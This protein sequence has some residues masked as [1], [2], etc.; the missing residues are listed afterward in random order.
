MKH[1]ILTILMILSGFSFAQDM[2]KKNM[3]YGNMA[4]NEGEFEDALKYFGN[5]VSY[6]PLDFKANFNLAN[7]KYRTEDYEG[8]IEGYEKIVNLGPTSLDKSKAYH[9][10]G[11]AFMMS[12]KLDDAIE[13]YKGGLRLNPSDEELRYNLA[14]ALQL[15]REQEDQ[16]RSNEN[17]EGGDGENG[18]PSDDENNGDSQDQ[19]DGNQDDQNNDSQN[20]PN[21]DEQDE[22]ESNQGEQDQQEGDQ[23]GNDQKFANKMS[24][25]EIQ[26]ILDNYY[27]REKN[28]QKKL[29]EGERVG[30]GA[31]R[32]KDW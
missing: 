25:D 12:Q 22:N 4:F 1:S 2:T 15:K 24:K 21:Q 8:A 19:N 18:N 3:Y 28:L 14:Y 20:D 7:A 11:N 30:Y 32:K 31:P 13:A 6:S 16:D 26:Q 17:S 27:R 10:M 29:A 23:D 9:N 5:A